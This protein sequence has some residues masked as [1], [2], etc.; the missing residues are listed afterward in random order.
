MA[1]KTTKKETKEK[2]KIDFNPFIKTTMYEMIQK[3]IPYIKEVCEEYEGI[4]PMPADKWK[5][6]DSLCVEIGICCAKQDCKLDLRKE[7]FTRGKYGITQKVRE[8]DRKRF[9]LGFIGRMNGEVENDSYC[10]YM[11]Y[12]HM[13][14]MCSETSK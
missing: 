1:K 8:M 9:I 5:L 4:E 2:E 3:K 11:I 13:N 6:F 7:P 10:C 14:I 12:L